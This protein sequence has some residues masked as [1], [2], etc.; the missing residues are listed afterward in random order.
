MIVLGP[1]TTSPP[2][3]IPAR[4]VASVR[5]SATMPAQPL[6]SIPAPSGR[7]D[8]SG[9]SPTATRIVVAGSSIMESGTGA[10]TGRPF[11]VAPVGRCS[12]QRRPATTPSR[13]TTSA[14]ARPGRIEMPSRSAASISSSWAGMSLRPRR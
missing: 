1:D 2:A 7:I 8:G 12:V 3:K 10:Q 6:T 5:G 14:T 13:P 9:S 11:S 4:P